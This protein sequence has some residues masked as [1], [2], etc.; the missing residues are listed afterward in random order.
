MD[1]DLEKYHVTM[2]KMRVNLNA[3]SGRYRKLYIFPICVF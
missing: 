1:I 3:T 2:Q